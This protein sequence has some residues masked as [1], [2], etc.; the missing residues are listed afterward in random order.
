M[1]DESD[2]SYTVYE[3]PDF[4]EQITNLFGFLLTCCAVCDN[5]P[6]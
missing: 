4:V 1:L 2:T 3:H 5:C 6:H